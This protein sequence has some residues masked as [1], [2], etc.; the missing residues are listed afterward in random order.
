MKY[1]FTLFSIML[2]TYLTVISKSSATFSV[3]GVPELSEGEQVG[4]RGNIL[5]LSWDKSLIM[6]STG[7]GWTITITLDEKAE[8]VEY[9]YVVESSKNEETVWELDG[10]ENRIATVSTSQKF[11]DQWDIM[12]AFPINDLV[13]IPSTKLLEDVEILGEV[14]WRIH[15]GIFKYNDSVSFYNNLDRLRMSFQTD[16]TYREAYKEISR[17]AGTLKCSHTYA[18]FFN[19][20]GLIKEI[21]LEQ[22]DKLPFGLT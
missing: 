7:L 6:E 19:Q 16:R 17:F 2:G 10:Y 13:K 11:N 14:M 4:I 1:F 18:N 3:S 8:L 21:I 15:P 22:P 12:G 9:K 20:I 5:P